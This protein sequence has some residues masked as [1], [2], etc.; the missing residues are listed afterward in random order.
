MSTGALNVSFRDS[1][2]PYAQRARLMLAASMIA[3]IAVFAGGISGGNAW[4]AV[5]V[6]AI[7]AFWAGMMVTL[8]TAVADLAVMSLVML[9]VFAGSPQG[10]EHPVYAGLF[11]FAGGLVQ[12][13]LSVVFWPL[14][15][16]EP[17]RRA[18]SDLY[19]GLARAAAAP[20]STSQIP[21]ASA[22]ITAAH[23]ALAA[24][25]RDDSGEAMRYRSLLNQ[26]ERIR[27]S[28]VTLAR[29]RGRMERE[30][31]GSAE[32]RISGQALEACSG[33]LRV[34]GNSLATEQLEAEVR[35]SLDDL[36]GFA[37]ELRTGDSSSASPMTA[38]RRDAR[39]Q[40]DALAGQLRAACEL[41]SR[42]T[43]DGQ[44]AERRERA[45]PRNLRPAGRLA[46]L[47]ANW[48]LDSA[49]FRHAVR[50]A[51]CIALGDAL[52]R[53][54][55]LRRAYWLPVTVAIVLKPDFT[56][57]FSRGVL[58]LAGTFIGLVFATVLFHVLPAAPSAHIV[59]LA[60]LMFMLRC[61]GPANYGIQ[62]AGLSSLVVLLIAMTGV[63]P[64]EVV[65]ARA[66]NTV[67]GGAIALAA[68]WLW[69]TWERTQFPEAMAKMLDAH[70]R[71]VHAI[72]ANYSTPELA[73]ELDR[74]RL[75]SR[76]ARTNLE[77]SIERLRAEPGYPA[78]SLLSG[79][80]ASSL[81]VGYSLLALDAALHVERDPPSDTF[82]AFERDVESTL[83][84]LA[85]ALRG[86]PLMAD[87]L[88]DLREDHHALAKPH[89]LVTVEA[90]RIVNSLNTLTE[91]LMQW[92]AQTPRL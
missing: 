9:L 11:A 40:M 51:V 19:A 52:A 5:P 32:P 58:R 64:K 7:W 84:R 15:P 45:Q 30:E 62:V 59:A 48:S 76:L 2:A 23:N 1:A 49:A 36:Q 77:A 47:R 44:A 43:P 79:I 61:F 89:S 80:Q 53:G 39:F 66:W 70:R 17:E 67:A 57:T 12:T 65:D 73:H 88:P 46:I 22:A 68:Y 86:S 27:I 21:P 81:R 90:D 6:A 16:Y 20:V 8:G 10:L 69:P 25:D 85:A 41:A 18:L 71:Y 63:A 35:Q 28:L 31:N 29:L 72:A 14:R 33:V 50:L 13:A 87:A 83:E 34:I 54:L 38:L 37:E 82:R 74:A 55:N 24:L 4:T 78:G 3:G 75:A 60:V 26:A 91:E 42:T 56:A 92:I